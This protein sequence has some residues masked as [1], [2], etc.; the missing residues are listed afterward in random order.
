MAWRKCLPCLYFFNSSG[1]PRTSSLK[2]MEVG[3][4]NAVRTFGCLNYCLK[5]NGTALRTPLDCSTRISELTQL[6]QRRQ[7]RAEDPRLRKKRAGWRLRW[8]YSHDV[9]RLEHVLEFDVLHPEPLELLTLAPQ[10]GLA[11]SQVTLQHLH[12]LLGVWGD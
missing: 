8:V 6:V 1:T 10:K 11:L 9:N 5:S 7:V 12:L 3:A 2:V 4:V